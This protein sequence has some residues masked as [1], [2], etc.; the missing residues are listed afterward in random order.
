MP[1]QPSNE[2]EVPP[3]AVMGGPE[4]LRP[5]L[6]K[7]VA[8]DENGAIVG[9]GLTTRDASDAAMKSGAADF[10]LQFVPPHRFVG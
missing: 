7:W 9:V 3:I 8:L 5:H 1:H 4:A 2:E 10:A 6:G